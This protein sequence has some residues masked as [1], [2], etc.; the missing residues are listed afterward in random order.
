MSKE[1]WISQHRECCCYFPWSTGLSVAVAAAGLIVWIVNGRR[2][3][4]YT[5]I[6]IDSL[7]IVKPPELQ[8]ISTGLLAAAISF[9]VCITLSLLLQMWRSRISS[10]VDDEGKA[11]RASG[12]YLTVNFLLNFLNWLVVLFLVLLIASFAVWAA[13]CYAVDKGA[14]ATY[15]IATKAQDLAKQG[16]STAQGFLSFY[17]SFISGLKGQ[18]GSVPNNAPLLNKIIELDTAVSGLRTTVRLT[19]VCPVYCLDTTSYSFLSGNGCICD[20]LVLKS[21]AEAAS[22]AWHALIPGIIGMLLMYVGGSWVTH[23]LVAAYARTATEK[24]LWER[25][26]A[27]EGRPGGLPTVMAPPGEQAYDMGD[28]DALPTPQGQYRSPGGKRNPYQQQLQYVG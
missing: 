6:A 9:G 27:T 22:S 24:D 1:R 18:L 5:N 10:H 25:M 3:F 2:A 14:G 21:A 8:F 15:D 17:D 16:I 20:T 23:L 19:G 11:S 28:Y 26:P 4:D 7:Q 13:V 12:S